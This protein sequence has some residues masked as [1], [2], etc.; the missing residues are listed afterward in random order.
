MGAG[1]DLDEP[2]ND[3]AVPYHQQ[4]IA[5]AAEIEQRLAAALGGEWAGALICAGW[6]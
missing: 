3:P 4:H 1:A 2:G 6:P 5:A